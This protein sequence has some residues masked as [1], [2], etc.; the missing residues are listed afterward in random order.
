MKAMTI[1]LTEY[2]DAN[3][4]PIPLDPAQVRRIGFGYIDTRDSSE[5]TCSLDAIFYRP[6]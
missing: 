5:Y 2:V 4:A 3:G 6:A 1:H